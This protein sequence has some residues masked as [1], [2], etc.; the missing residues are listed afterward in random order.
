MTTDGVRHPLFA[1]VL[2]RLSRLMEREL[3]ERRSELLAGLEGRVVELGAGNGMNFGQYPPSVEEVVALEP[4]PYLHA[5]AQQAALAAPV[6]VT[7]IEGVADALPLEDA[8]VDAAVASLVLCTVPDQSGALSELRRVLK[9]GGELR[10]LEHVCS[11]HRTKARIQE[12]LD[13]SGIW[14]RVAGG[15]HCSRDTVRA[16]RAANFHLERVGSFDLGPSWIF[17]NPHILGLARA[18]GIEPTGSPQPRD[19]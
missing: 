19:R 12:G 17:T 3:G 15:C 5:K 11:D 10:F 2:H 14:P 4:E 1:R 8:S 6:R 9:P 7:V 16:L 13:R 18:P